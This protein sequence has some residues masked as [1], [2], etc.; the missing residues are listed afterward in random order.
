V[1]QRQLPKST[2]EQRG[3]GELAAAR[4]FRAVQLLA[5]TAATALLALVATG[6]P[7]AADLA[8]PGMYDAPAPAGGTGNT[9]GSGST[10][11]MCETECMAKIINA[12]GTGCKGCHGKALKS[13][14][15]MD[16]ESAGYTG[17]LVD[18][19]AEHMGVEM[20]AACPSGDKLIDSANPSA[21]WLLKK[22]TNMQGTCGVVMP[23][24][25]A[26]SAAD[27]AC[28]TTYVNCAAGKPGG[29]G[30]SGT[31]GASG[32]TGGAAGGT[33]GAAGG[34]GGAAGGTGGGGGTGGN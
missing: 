10:G 25:G 3:P 9:A 11:S 30:G 6:C 16:L 13:G 4:R 21:S 1:Q 29:A 26:L 2:S 28:V 27:Q 24:T 17:R 8:N 12:Q 34:T 33:G 5:G 20:G 19:P 31:G 15:M 32:G 18:K 22:V 23:I 7:E 14:G